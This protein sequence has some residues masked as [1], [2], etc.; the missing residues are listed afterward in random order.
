MESFPVPKRWLSL[1]GLYFHRK[2]GGI[3]VDEEQEYV[4]DVFNK[5]APHADLVDHTER[6]H[7]WVLSSEKLFHFVKVLLQQHSSVLLNIQGNV[8]W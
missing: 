3:L 2:V 5:S 7:W 6:P 8:V 4:D 1:C